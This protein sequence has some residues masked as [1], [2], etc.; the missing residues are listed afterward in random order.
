MEITKEH[1]AAGEA[2]PPQADD[3]YVRDFYWSC[4]ASTRCDTVLSMVRDPNCTVRMLCFTCNIAGFR[5]ISQWQLHRTYDNHECSHT[6]LQDWLSPR[7]S[8]YWRVQQYFRGFLVDAGNDK[9][10]AVVALSGFRDRTSF[11]MSNCFGA[12]KAHSSTLAASAW[13]WQKSL[14]WFQAPFTLSRFSDS[15]LSRAEHNELADDFYNTRLCRLDFACGRKLRRRLTR[16]SDIFLPRNQRLCSGIAQCP[17]HDGPV[18]CGHARNDR[19]NDQNVAWATFCA[20]YCLAEGEA[21]RQQVDA[22]R[23]YQLKCITQAP[24]PPEPLPVAPGPESDQ[25]E[26]PSGMT[27]EAVY[28]QKCIKQLKAD[29]KAGKIESLPSVC[30]PEFWKLCGDR[31]AD[32]SIVSAE[33]AASC[34]RIGTHNAA[35]PRKGKVKTALAAIHQDGPQ[36][37]LSLTNGGSG[38]AAATSALCLPVGSAIALRADQRCGCCGKVGAAHRGF[39]ASMDS[40]IRADVSGTDEHV[41][42]T[43]QG[44]LSKF[45]IHESRWAE[46]KAQWKGGVQGISAMFADTTATVG[47][48]LGGVPQDLPHRRRCLFLCK[49][50]QSDEQRSLTLQLKR[51]FRS[52]VSHCGG[53]QS[54]PDVQPCLP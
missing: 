53:P 10:H 29:K 38:D 36:Q 48:N 41:T 50:I 54:V 4:V 32:R 49:H 12:R 2:V 21:I 39:A 16:P 28:R 23:A 27:A 1:G 9:Y 45:P 51:H 44:Q 35:K 31:L 3:E 18:E 37:T 7:H 13:A 22:H 15:R 20:E 25:E 17:M 14:D 52:I 19:H 43:K 34:A 33:E 24:P 5:Y 40:L 26:L 47:R 6:A 46:E 8:P 30:T 42:G 11:L